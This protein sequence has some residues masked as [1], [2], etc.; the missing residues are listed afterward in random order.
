EITI[1]PATCYQIASVL[2]DDVDVTATVIA[3]NGV[4]TFENVI[5]NHTIAATFEQITY[6][7]TATAG[8]GGTI[9]ATSAVNCGDDKEITIVPATCY[10]IASVLV[11]DVDVTATVIAANGVYTFENVTANHT[12]A[13]TFA[14]NTYN[15]TTT[16]EGNGTING[17]STANCGDNKSYTIA[18][19][20]TCYR[21]A[22]F[23]VDNVDAFTDL[24]ENGVYAMQNITADHVLAATFEQIT[25]TITATAG[26]NGTITETSEVNCGVNKEI[27][28][29]PATCYQIASV[30]V[31]DVDV[32]ATVIAA[33]GVYTFE[34]VTAD[35]TIAATFEQITYT[36]TVYVGENG[37]ITPNDEGGVTVNCGESKAFTIA[38]NEHYRIASVAVDDADVTSELVDGVYTFVNVTSNHTIAATFEAI[39]VYT[40]TATADENGTIT[41]AEATVEEG[42][43]ADF[44]IA[45]NEGYRIASVIVDGE[46]NVTS[47]VIANNGVYRFTNVI[48]NHTI[49]A[50]FEVIPATTYTITAI[51]GENG[52]I[53]P[54]GEVVVTEGATQAFTIVANE[55][56]RIASV[57]VDEVESIA[58]LVEGV[59]TFENVMANHTIAATFEVIPATTYTITATAGENG[60]I[61]P[62]GEVVVT[63][64]ATQ[65]FTI[66]ANEGYRIASVM[67]DEVESIASL[68]EGVYTFENVTAD[69]TIAATFEAIPT[70]TLTI[71]YVFADNTPAAE[72]HVET[73]VEGAEYSVASPAVTG[74]TADQLVVEGTM[75]ANDVVVNV[76]YT[77][78]TYTITATAGDNGTITPNGEVVVN[79]GVTQDFTIEANDGYRIMS[80]LVDG[81][82]AISELVEGV[83]TFTNVAENHTIAATFVSEAANTYTITATASENGTI[84]PSGVIEV[85]EGESKSFTIE[86]AAGYHIVSVMVDETENVTEQLVNGVYTFENVTANH[87]IAAAFAIN[88]YMITATAGD[89]GTITPAQVSVNHGASQEFT[90]L[91]NEGYRIASVIVDETEDVTAEVVDN[92]YTFTNVTADHTIAATFEEIPVTTYTITATAGTNGTINPEGEVTVTAGENKEFTIT[93]N[94]G[95]R[96]ASVIVDETE[97]VTAQL[98][99]GVYTFVNVTAN[100][101]IAATFEEIPATTYTITATAGANGT[102]NPAGEVTAE[103]G[104]DVEFTITANEGYRIASVMVDETEDVTE[105]LVEGVYTFVNVT[106]NHTIAATFEEI[107][108]NTYTI[109]LTVGEHGSVTPSG[110]NGIV[111]ITEGEDITF[112]ITPDEGYLI[113]G[114]IVDETPVYCDVEGDVVNFNDVNANHTIEV[115]F[116]EISAT[117]Y[118][119]TATAGAN[120]TITPAG[121]V[122]VPAGENKEFTIV[123]NEGYRI[124]SVIVDAD[125]DD[126]E[127]VTDALENGVYTFENVT[128]NHTIHATF[129][130]ATVPNT[131]TVTITV[132]EH[133]TVTA[134]DEDDN[135]IAI[136]DGAITVNHGDDLYLEI[137]PDENY[138][139][140]TLAVNGVEYELDEEDELGLILPMLEITE[141]MAVSVTFTSVIAAEMFEAGSMTVYPNPNNGMFSIDFSNIEGAATYQIINANGAVV[142]TRDI[143]VMNGATM[144]FSHDLRPGTYFV[145]IINGDKVYVEQIVV[146]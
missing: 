133:G 124:A 116:T 33:N 41:P 143:N 120:G 132:G 129:E 20:N 61:T 138:K 24:D 88:N 47:E 55:G 113:G 34:N 130:D 98:V 82:E 35:H 7:I 77:I 117:T 128:A 45:A 64:G 93:A 42:G 76:T 19:A 53:T 80:V 109:T 43:N 119:I 44:T 49:A 102:I 65:A 87:T 118:T 79:Y 4:Y 16:V 141:D 18:P 57:M 97:D 10:H 2:V 125:T 46:F 73:L 74:Y 25:Y 9:T 89:N 122:T 135:E 23:T 121:E 111:T 70:Y 12:I 145:R 8:E 30:L 105:E 134:S 67:V 95:Y 51:A 69:H 27:T 13:A 3:A 68:V 91:A 110:E 112:T 131:H 6:T 136:V 66:V 17:E 72:D 15:I 103:E 5:A 14:I 126:E 81:A 36:I 38:A 28:I 54:N 48:A 21:I 50:A 22:S 106:A 84:T 11:D 60:T 101:T 86:A 1:T 115:V 52:T 107:P 59:Y 26:E 62:N 146:E 114:L 144:N 40:I 139:V 63:E 29:T 99:E 140:E 92:V 39:P 127:D 108:V 58:S 31:D 71:H 83:Y 90:I 104:E 75:P 85:V 142:E 100:H 94:E 56:Y 96:I 37:T 78:N 123:A 137:T 32:T